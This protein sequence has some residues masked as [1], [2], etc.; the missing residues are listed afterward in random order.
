[1]P[2][3][4]CKQCNTEFKA[5]TSWLKKGHG[6][7][8]SLQCKYK[9]TR[10]G[11]TVQCEMCGTD[12]YKTQKALKG[13]KSGKFFCSKSC[14]TIWR[15]GLYIQE[16]HPNWKD[17]RHSYRGVIQRHN[18]KPICTLCKITDK[19]VLAVHHIDEDRTNNNI[20]NLAWLCQNCHH[21]VHRYPDEQK[22]F[23]ATMV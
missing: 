4:S 9:G 3:V 22:R 14:Q 15:N 16:K 11:K 5:K 6:V 1:M 10:N 8:C 23:M 18:I 7:Y 17:G 12:T 2:Y 19:R 13:S 21:L 20:E